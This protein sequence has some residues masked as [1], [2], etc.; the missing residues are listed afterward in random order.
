MKVD[1]QNLEWYVST[2][3]LILLI[4]ISKL[5][6][7]YASVIDHVASVIDHVGEDYDS[8]SK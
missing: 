8:K 1:I 2:S 5:I 3:C 7:N 4:G 6:T